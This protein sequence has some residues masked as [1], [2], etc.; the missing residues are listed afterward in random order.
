MERMP[1][2]ASQIMVDRILNHPEGGYFD[3]KGTTGG[4]GVIESLE[5]IAGQAFRSA[6]ATLEERLGPFGEAWRWGKVKGTQLR[7][8]AR[9][10]GF[11][12]EKVEADGAGQVINAIDAVWAPSWRMV[13][14]LGDE[15]KAWGNYPGGQSG[16]PGSRAYDDRVDDW[17][18]GRSY[19]LVF[20][21]SADEAHPRVVG[22]TV[23]RGAK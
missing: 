1:R 8:L 11:G 22:R 19:E 20:L 2:P 15:V 5:D 18:A 10:P 14:E 17:A 6:V 16:N 3:D 9:I 7:H 13:V 12:R 4:D 23:M 21:R